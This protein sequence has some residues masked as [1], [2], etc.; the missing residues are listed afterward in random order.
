MN[1]RMTEG[2]QN[3]IDRLNNGRNQTNY[4][5][6]Y[7]ITAIGD[8]KIVHDFGDIKFLEREKSDGTKTFAFIT[9]NGNSDIWLN[10][11][12][13]HNQVIVLSKELAAYY[14]ELNLENKKAL[15]R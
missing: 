10:W 9:K 15:M 6:K 7:N 1:I 13:S 8:F 3:C 14:K 4:E 5:K 12:P 11:I 2:I